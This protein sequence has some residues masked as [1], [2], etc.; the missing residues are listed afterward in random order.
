MHDKS[1][2]CCAHSTP[3]ALLSFVCAIF[4]TLTFVIAHVVTDNLNPLAK[5]L[6]LYALEEHGFIIELGFYAIGLSQLLL[7]FLLFSH[8]KTKRL[9]SGSLFLLL[10]G[11][12]A[13]IV[14]T[15]PTLPAPA[16]IISRLPHIVGA[17]MQFFFFPL[18]A[19]TLSRKIT[20]SAFKTCTQLTGIVTTVLFVIML[21]LFLSPSMKDFS[22]FGLIEKTD[23]LVINFWLILISFILYRSKFKIKSSAL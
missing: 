17:M 23:I 6:S 10:A 8:I 4:F 15:F 14:A 16:S 3:T 12:G 13:I 2:G 20:N 7:A 5:T 11:L 21:I 9:M 22:Y 19:L 1:K 18:A